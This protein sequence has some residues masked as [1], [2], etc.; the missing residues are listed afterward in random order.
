[1]HSPIILQPIIIILIITHDS[2]KG[3]TGF[4]LKAPNPILKSVVMLLRVL[5][6]TK[7]LRVIIQNTLLYAGQFF[8]TVWDPNFATIACELNARTSRP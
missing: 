6:T 8:L 5:A 1:M 7:Q 4:S 3:H 2:V